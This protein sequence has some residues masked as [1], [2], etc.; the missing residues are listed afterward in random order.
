MD[1]YLGVALVGFPTLRECHANMIAVVKSSCIE[2]LTM[3]NAM[4]PW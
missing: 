2:E 4:L 1:Q 3:V